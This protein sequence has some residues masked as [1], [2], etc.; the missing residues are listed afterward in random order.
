MLK[1]RRRTSS[2]CDKD[3]S[4]ASS[5]EFEISHVECTKKTVIFAGFYRVKPNENNAGE[6]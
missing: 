2:S 6:K 4:D 1:K 5:T 3:D